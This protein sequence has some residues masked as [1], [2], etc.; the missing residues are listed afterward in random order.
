ME[1]KQVAS[2]L[3]APFSRATKKALSTSGSYVFDGNLI[4]IIDFYVDKDTSFFDVTGSGSMSD[5]ALVTR[6]LKAFLGH[7]CE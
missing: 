6:P 2:C 7:N 5:R 3:Y 4:W 1:G